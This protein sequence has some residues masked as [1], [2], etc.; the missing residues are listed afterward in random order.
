MVAEGAQERPY[1]VTP[2][3]LEAPRLLHAEARNLPRVAD[4]QVPCEAA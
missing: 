1:G 4:R 3:Y 2:R